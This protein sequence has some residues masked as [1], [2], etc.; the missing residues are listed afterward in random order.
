MIGFASEIEKHMV[1]TYMIVWHVRGAYRIFLILCTFGFLVRAFYMH[2]RSPALA[3]P[4]R[5][6][7]PRKIVRQK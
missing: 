7:C 6:V 5:I 3:R 4:R 2:R 1:H